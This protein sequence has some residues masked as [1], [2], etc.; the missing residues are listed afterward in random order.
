MNAK[1][2]SPPDIEAGIEAICKMYGEISLKEEEKQ[3]ATKFIIFKKK[4]KKMFKRCKKNM[5]RF[6]NLRVILAQGPC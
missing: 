4:E 6:T 5:E 3:S 1:P 2:T